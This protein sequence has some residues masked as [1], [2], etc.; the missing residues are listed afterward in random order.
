MPTW[1]RYTTSEPRTYFEWDDEKGSL[2][3]CST[4][5]GWV[6]VHDGEAEGRAQAAQHLRD[7]HPNTPATHSLPAE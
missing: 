6:A 3:R 5:P 2:T 4:C 1:D 7:T